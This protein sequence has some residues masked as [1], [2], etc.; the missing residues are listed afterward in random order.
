MKD[1]KMGSGSKKASRRKA[2]KK[3]EAST[4]SDM[5]DDDDDTRMDEDD[6]DDDEEEDEEDEAEGE[7]GLQARYQ[8][9]LGDQGGPSSQSMVDDASFTRY[10]KS[11]NIG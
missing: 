10:L 7:G 8:K 9:A 5:E 3:Q 6:D 2:P 4:L 11:S 1:M